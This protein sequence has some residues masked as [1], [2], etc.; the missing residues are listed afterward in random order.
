MKT[1]DFSQKSRWI[2]DQAHSEISFKVRH[3]MIS[4]V[5]GSFK[6]FDATN[7]FTKAKDFTTAEIEFWID[8]SSIFTG[9]SKRDEHLK[10][11]DFLDAES[12]K[13]ITFTS[14]S[15]GKPDTEGNH[16]LLGVL[17]IKGIAKKVQLN[18]QF[19]GIINDPWKNEK[20]G[21]TVTGKINRSDW[22]LVWN[23]KLES[24]GLLVSD[25]VTI[26]CEVELSNAGQIDLTAQLEPAIEQK[27]L[28]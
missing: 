11:Y 16:K 12:F 8:A 10:G 26:L 14:E 20:A 17:T 24:G 18:V 23:T 2:I 3:L 13:L 21:F 27:I 1:T 7:I 15:I 4:N 19:G 25:E 6:T 28:I 5:K 22:G 9:D